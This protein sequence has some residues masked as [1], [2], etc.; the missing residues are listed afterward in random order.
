M[1][2]EEEIRKEEG[3]RGREEK[4]GKGR[5]WK[6]AMSVVILQQCPPPVSALKSSG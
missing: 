4:E 6:R 2:G 1:K 5:E 3:S